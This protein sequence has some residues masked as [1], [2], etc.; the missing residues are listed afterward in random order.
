MNIHDFYKYQLCLDRVLLKS[1]LMTKFLGFKIRVTHRLAFWV[2]LTHWFI[3]WAIAK[4]AG[5]GSAVQEEQQN[6]ACV[7]LPY[8]HF[9]WSCLVGG[10]ANPWCAG[11]CYLW[12][13]VMDN[14]EA[15]LAVCD[16]QWS[17]SFY[18]WIVLCKQKG[19]KPLFNCT[20]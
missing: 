11:L 4:L 12:L 10:E 18:C 14:A 3:L 6:T 17:L 16:R 20:I 7:T 15:C 2:A 8:W 13:L 5:M 1:V 19:Q 9:T